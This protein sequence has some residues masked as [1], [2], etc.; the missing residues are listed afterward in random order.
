[1]RGLAPKL[2]LSVASLFGYRSG[3]IPISI[4]AWSKLE[5]LEAATSGLKTAEFVK[6][7][8]FPNHHDWDYGKESSVLRDDTP[9]TL[10]ER[11]E[12]LEALLMHVAGQLAE[13]SE[14]IRKSVERDR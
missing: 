1:M 14:I 13:V 10:T 2:G 12:R 8:T 3:K 11:V 9:L 7:V 5:H 4:K 6:S